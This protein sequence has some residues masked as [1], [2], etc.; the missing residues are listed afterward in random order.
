VFV[1]NENY[2]LLYGAGNSK[3]VLEVLS[4]AYF[5]GDVRTRKSRIGKVSVYARSAAEWSS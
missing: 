1:G 4:N 2:G 3:L 5:T